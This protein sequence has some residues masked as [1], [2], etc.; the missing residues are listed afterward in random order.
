MVE[1]DMFERGVRAHRRRG[2]ELFIVDR[3]YHPA[4][5]ALKI[6][7]RLDDR[8]TTP[9]ARGLFNLEINADPQPFAGSGLRHGGPAQRPS[10]A[11]VRLAAADAG[12]DPGARGHPPP[13]IGKTDLGLDNMVPNPRYLTLSRAMNNARGEAFD[14]S[15]RGPRRARGQARLGD[16]RGLQRELPVHLRLAD[17]DRFAQALTLGS[18]CSRRCS[19]PPPTRQCSSAYGSGARP[20]SPSSSGP[21]HPHA[22][23][24]PARVSR[25][26]VLRAEWLRGSVVDLY[27]E[28]VARFGALVDFRAGG[29][30]QRRA[31][32]RRVPDMKALRLHNGT[33]YRWN[34]ACYGIS[35]NRQGPP[36]HRAAGAP[37]GPPSPTQVASSAAT[38]AGADG[39]AARATI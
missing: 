32:R 13:T 25:A 28:N 16:G 3:A 39:E 18:C 23:A 12:D 14:F 35:E 24:A 1:G 36:A 21:G 27:K 33:I 34:R 6:P 19:R 26:R 29:G 2:R 17:P 20:A 31:R 30:R 11:K 9:R 37:Q 5:G 4:P 15:I 10:P 7:E 8:R 22:G 38:L